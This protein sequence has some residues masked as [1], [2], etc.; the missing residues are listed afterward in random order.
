MLVQY[1]T[2]RSGFALVTFRAVPDNML[3]QE[4]GR[5]SYRQS[6]L[7]PLFMRVDTGSARELKHH[8]KPELR[9]LGIIKVS[10]N[11][12]T[13]LQYPGL[14]YTEHLELLFCVLEDY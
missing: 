8:S 13:Y 1:D 6:S 11:I 14:Q 3:G 7:D 9:A 10:T 12:Y 5:I 2:I 4:I